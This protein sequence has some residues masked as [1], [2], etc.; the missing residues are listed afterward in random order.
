MSAVEVVPTTTTSLG[1]LVAAKREQK[2]AIGFEDRTI[3]WYIIDPTGELIREQRRLRWRLKQQDRVAAM[4]SAQREAHMRREK[5]R[6]C[7]S[8]FLLNL[9]MPTLYPSW[10][11]ITAVALIFTAFVTPFEVGYLPSPKRWDEPLFII[12]RIIDCVFVFDMICAF[13]LMQRADV[14][15]HGGT[16]YEWE[17]RLH[18]LAMNYLK[19][20]FLIDVESVAPSIFDILPVLGMGESAGAIKT[21]RTVRRLPH[22]QSWPAHLLSFSRPCVILTLPGNPFLCH[23]QIRTLRL[24]KL[25]RLV[26]TS[27]V[28]ARLAAYASMSS[29]ANTI[30][31][32]AIKFLMAVHGYAC[33]VAISSTL[34]P[35]RLDSWVATHGYVSA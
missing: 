20:W 1:D 14:T 34:A 32:L 3:P 29:F 31:R 27:K 5:Q 2:R 10:D 7:L 4:T 30:L 18:V 19:C 9:E 33:I 11:V 6:G 21:M 13:F 35:S 24:I 16:A 28:V 17:M 26:R 25:L 23:C 12:N 8:R 22:V 15:K